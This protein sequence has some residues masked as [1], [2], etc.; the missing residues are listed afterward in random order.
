[1]MVFIEQFVAPLLLIVGSFLCITGAIGMLRFP[2]FF[3][4]MH[5]TSVTE[6]LGAGL[7]LFA[8]MLLS[9]GPIEVIKLALVLLFLLCTGPTAVHA[10]AK[11][12]LTAGLVPRQSTKRISTETKRELSSKA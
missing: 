8:L 5:A 6:T 7:I 4:R 9:N 3:T 10:L 12:A 2:D 1:M 11:S